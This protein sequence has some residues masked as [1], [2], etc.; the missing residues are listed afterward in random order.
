VATAKFW[1][2]EAGHRIASTAQH[3]HGGI[4]VDMDY[5]MHRFFLRA[6]DIEFAL[7]GASTQLATIWTQLE[8]Q[9]L[10]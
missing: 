5:P 8:S 4:G 2:A 3:V 9:V 10:S 1:A 7:G 6:K